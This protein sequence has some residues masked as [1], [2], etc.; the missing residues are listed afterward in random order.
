[1]YCE[2][3][4]EWRIFWADK[5][6]DIKESVGKTDHLD[7]MKED[8]W[9]ALQVFMECYSESTTP[10]LDADNLDMDLCACLI[11]AMLNIYNKDTCY[12]KYCEFH[13]ADWDSEEI[14]GDI[15][16]FTENELL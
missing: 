8:S 14:D 16:Y 11:L 13:F 7:A 6:R 12:T 9:R 4:K 1:M 5:Y 10:L 2:L 15:I 3:F